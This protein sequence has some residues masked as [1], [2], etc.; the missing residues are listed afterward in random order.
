[1]IDFYLPKRKLAIEIDE[2]GNFD[3]D[4]ITENKRQKELKEYL[5]CIFIRINPDEN[6]FNTYDGL[7]KIQ[8][9]I[10]KL[11]DEELEKLKEKVKELKEDK[12]HY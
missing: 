10:D 6:D 4:Q 1:M 9:F 11:K 5:G 7:G 8:T 12:N 2:L 3:R